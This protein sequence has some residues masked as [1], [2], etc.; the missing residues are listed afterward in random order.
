MGTSSIQRRRPPR[1]AAGTTK[2]V[3]RRGAQPERVVHEAARPLSNSR[4][5]GAADDVRR[6]EEPDRREGRGARVRGEPRRPRCAP[7]AVRVPALVAPE[8]GALRRR[9]RA[10]RVETIDV[11]V[12]HRPRAQTRRD[13]A[14]SLR[15]VTPATPG[16]I[17]ARPVELSRRRTGKAQ[18]RLEP[19]LR[20]A[21]EG[22][23]A[24]RGVVPWRRIGV[25][26]DLC[27]LLFVAD[28][29]RP[30][31]RPPVGVVVVRG[32][33]WVVV[34]PLWWCR[35]LGRRLVR[36][37]QDERRRRTGISSRDALRHEGL[38]GI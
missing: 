33:R 38:A 32:R 6:G 29:A 19:A 7:H 18:Q 15:R 28:A 4:R 26:R 35:R 1:R 36:R 17:A 9:G 20:D 13:H 31:R 37:R 10:P 14:P 27:F 16:I 21:H 2:V 12:P 22:R 24:A 34:S 30:S 23:R 3:R 5:D 25:P 11:H 8:P